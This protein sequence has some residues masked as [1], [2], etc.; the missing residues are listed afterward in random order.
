MSRKKYS[1]EALETGLGGQTDGATS[2]TYK[3][4]KEFSTEAGLLSSDGF[5]IREGSPDWLVAETETMRQGL[6][7]LQQNVC[8]LRDPDDPDAFYPRIE[9]E[10]TSS[11]AELEGWARDHM[12]WLYDDYF[13][14]RQDKLWRDNARRTLPAL[15]G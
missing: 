9:M 3:F 5:K 6:I 1:G 14:H 2:M 12:S 13:F 10:K 8:L 4:R 7:H 15:I 11:Y